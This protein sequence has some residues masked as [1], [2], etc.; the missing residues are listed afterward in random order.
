MLQHSHNSI[1]SI[2]RY[3]EALW[4]ACIASQW[5]DG[6]S[7]SAWAPEMTGG[8]GPFDLF[9]YLD[10]FGSL[11]R[12]ATDHHRLF[13]DVWLIWLFDIFWD[14]WW[15]DSMQFYVSDKYIKYDKSLNQL[16][17]IINE[18]KQINTNT[19]NPIR[20]L[21]HIPCCFSTHSTFQQIYHDISLYHYISDVNLI[22]YTIYIYYIYVF[23][24]VRYNIYNI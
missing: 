4:T 18:L 12:E 22:I 15:C 24:I 13:W 6:Q 1:H 21:F 16:N 7:Q 17:Q 8:P 10:G 14:L 5:Q 3:P 2:L 23:F 19:S 9:G 11:A 20:C